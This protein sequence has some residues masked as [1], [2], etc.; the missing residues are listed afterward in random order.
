MQCE[1]DAAT[2]TTA[3]Q[4]CLR[5]VGGFVVYS[6]ISSAYN[7]NIYYNCHNPL[8]YIYL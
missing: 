7:R 1:T 2:S 3:Q 4:L 8:I 6:G 5:C